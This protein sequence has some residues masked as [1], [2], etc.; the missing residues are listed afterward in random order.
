MLSGMLTVTD[1]WVAF[2]RH[3]LEAL[4]RTPVS[5]E[6]RT[7]AWTSCDYTRQR[8]TDDLAEWHRMLLARL[9]D[10]D[11]EPLLDK[12]VHHR[13]LGGPELVFL[14]ARL[15]HQRGDTTTA[16]TLVAA[17]LGKRPGDQELL[18]FATEINA[19]LP[20]RASETLNE[21]ARRR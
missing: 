6:N 5:S 1:M 8:R 7:Y 14:Q 2:A 17:A 16:G 13:A 9:P 15:A 10:T 12:L 11:A 18:A 19:P 3:Y 21:R 4:D 20:A